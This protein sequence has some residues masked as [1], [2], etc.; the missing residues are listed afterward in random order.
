MN[1]LPQ[2]QT[3]LLTLE[4]GVL[5]I[6]LNRP[7]V[8]NAMSLAMVEELR[9]VFAYL[10]SDAE[11]RAVVLRGAGGQFCAG[12]DLKDMAQARGAGIAAY[13]QLNR[14]FGHLLQEAE[15]LPQVLI[16]LLEGAVLG[17]GFGLACVSDLALAHE[18]AQFGL[19]ETSLGILPAQ[20]APFVIKRIGLTQARRLALTAARFNGQ[21]ALQLGLVH[22][23]EYSTEALEQRL[24]EQLALVK[25]CAPQANAHTK[26]LL[27]TCAEQ[28]LD[29]VLDQAA[30]QF[31]QAVAGSEG[32][33]GAMAF[34]QKRAPR[35][36][37]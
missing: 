9:A 22:W 21:Q 36:A 28:P 33:E 32:S 25:R 29:T 8:R 4:A 18:E 3:L 12:G 23:A 37:Q 30:E 34:L 5:Q 6:T 14:A 20:I 27:L 31:A 24:A 10:H 19:P 35:W 7:E 2:C 11:I 15:R 17:G 1:H 13:R 26:A 16:C